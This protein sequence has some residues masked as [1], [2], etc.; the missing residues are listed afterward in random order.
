M[1]KTTTNDNI[2]MPPA[3]LLKILIIQRRNDSLESIEGYYKM[4]CAGAGAPSNIVKAR[5][6][7][8]FLDLEAGLKR[9]L[10]EAKYKQLIVNVFSEDITKCIEGFREINAFLDTMNLIKVDTKKR[11]DSTN[12]EEENSTKDL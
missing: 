3:E 11:Y 9:Q 2:T 4:L 1:I 6:R 7:T 10:E 5:V 12:A 8:L